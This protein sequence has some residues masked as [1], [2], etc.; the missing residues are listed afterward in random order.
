MANEHSGRK[1]PVGKMLA[2]GAAAI[3][4]YAALLGNQETINETFGKG[5]MNAFLPIFTAFLFSIV[6]G[7]FTGSFWTVLGIEAKRKKENR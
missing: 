1:K 7:S 6:H 5:G 4:L 3:A 2:A